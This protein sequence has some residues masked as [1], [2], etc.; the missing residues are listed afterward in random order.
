MRLPVARWTCRLCVTAALAT[1]RRVAASA[2]Q[3]PRS[4]RGHDSSAAVLAEHEH[5]FEEVL[6]IPERIG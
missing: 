3:G 5:F 2:S 6:R 4:R 1:T